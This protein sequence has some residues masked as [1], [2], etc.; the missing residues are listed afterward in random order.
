MPLTTY[1]FKSAINGFFEMPRGNA[2]ELLPPHLQPIELRHGQSVLAVTAFDF[3]ESMVG[4]YTELFLAVIVPPLV[5]P[6]EAMPKSAFYPFMVA[7]STAA[8]RAHAIERWHLPH[9]MKDIT[10]E[11]EESDGRVNVHAREG[12]VPILDFAISQHAWTDANDL[13]QSFMH[14]AEDRFK[15]NV[16]L[17]GRFSEHEE[18][19]GELVFHDHPMCK[20]LKVNEIA[21]YPFREMW[22][23]D[24]VQTFQE[25]ESI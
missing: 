8:A 21:A 23:K 1:G 13:Y 17:K 19:T 3:T 14:T 12:A 9:Y 16:F 4:P 2:R 24:G 25:L 15:V 10:V 22:M 6:G 20:K 11:F 5:R 7:T 18:E